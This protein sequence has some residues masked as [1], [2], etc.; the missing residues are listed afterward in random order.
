MFTSKPG[1]H[2]WR[3]LKT[4]SGV[5]FARVIVVMRRAV[6]DGRRFDSLST[7]QKSQSSTTAHLRSML[8][9]K[10]ELHQAKKVVG[11]CYFKAI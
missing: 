3:S 8:T 11:T 6:V 1:E 5:R 9:E 7:S 10:I 2:L 4:L